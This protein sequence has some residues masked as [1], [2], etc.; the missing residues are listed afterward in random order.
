M[1]IITSQPID[2]LN[3]IL[4]NCYVKDQIHFI[5]SCK[6]LFYILFVNDLSSIPTKNLDNNILKQ[7]KFKNLQKLDASGSC[8]INQNGICGL[9]FLK[10][11]YA[12]DNLKIVNVSFMHNL[13]ILSAGGN[14]GI[15][16]NGNR[17]TRR[18]PM[19][20]QIVV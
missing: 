4:N 13:E 6:K 17:S 8:G 19:R 12:Y 11:L 9:N 16:Q 15:D 14:C 2:I 20:G 5:S 3:K 10:K 18:F 1:E 7:Q